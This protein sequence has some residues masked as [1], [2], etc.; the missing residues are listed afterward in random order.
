MV[1]PSTIGIGL[2]IFI[3]IVLSFLQRLLKRH[4]IRPIR[5]TAAQF[6]G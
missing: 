6:M 2:S 5:G 3:F 4:K 1:V